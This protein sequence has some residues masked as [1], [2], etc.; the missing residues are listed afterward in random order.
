MFWKTPAF[1][2][3]RICFNPIA[4]SSFLYLFSNQK[5]GEA[6]DTVIESLLANSNLAHE[7]SGTGIRLVMWCSA[8]YEGFEETNDGSAMLAKFARMGAADDA[9]GESCW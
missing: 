4:S 8:V 2:T 6:A 3:V 1:E 9:S 7:K 5:H